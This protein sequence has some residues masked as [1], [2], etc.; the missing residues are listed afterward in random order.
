MSPGPDGA[1]A[2]QISRLLLNSVMTCLHWT[3]L[4]MKNLILR[5]KHF[6][7][8]NFPIILSVWASSLGC[9]LNAPC[10]LLVMVTDYFSETRV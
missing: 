10:N 1:P 6:F 7:S 4:T 9:Q 2:P 3:I 8:L 5:R